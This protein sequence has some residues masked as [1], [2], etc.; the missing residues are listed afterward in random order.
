MIVLGFYLSSRNFRSSERK[1]KRV[2]EEK[3]RLRGRVLLLLHGGSFHDNRLLLCHDN[4]LPLRHD[5]RLLI[6]R[7]RD[8]NGLLNNHNLLSLLVFTAAAS[9][10][11]ARR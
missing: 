9:V 2:A 8:W 4:R 5:N 1:T 10:C 7:G 11:V 6:C 3:K